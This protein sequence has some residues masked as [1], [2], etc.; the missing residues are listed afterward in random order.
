M[1]QCPSGDAPTTCRSGR[2]GEAGA[3]PLR[4][5]PRVGG[6]WMGLMGA[7]VAV[8]GEDDGACAAEGDCVRG[9]CRLDRAG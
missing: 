5:V 2:F 1:F 4:R 6:G 9:G 8:A 7:W 3:S